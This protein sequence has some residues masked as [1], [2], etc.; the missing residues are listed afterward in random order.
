MSDIKLGISLYC[1]TNE[2][3]KLEFS[4][5]DCV[6]TAAELGATGYEIVAAQMI[7][8][9]PNVS[10]EFLAQVK[11]WKDK[12][13][14]APVSYGA[15]MDCGMV[16]GR[17]LTLE[18]MV[19]RAIIDIKSASKL[20]CKIVRQQYLLSAEGLRRIEPYAR[21]Y[22]IKVGIEMHNPETPKSKA[23][24]EYLKVIK[25]VGSEYIGLIPDF[26]CFATKPN[27]PHWEEALKNGADEKHLELAAQM[28][29]DGL[30]FNQASEKLKEVG[31]APAVFVALQ[32]MYGFVTFYNEPDVEGLKEIM[33]Y[34]IHFHGK[35]HYLDENNVEASIPYDKVLEV[36]KDSDFSG[37]IVSE[38]E[39]QASG[40][41]VLMTKRHLE[42]EKAILGIK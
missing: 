14:I 6:R 8:S 34:C 33:P 5:E 16:K 17:D 42:M 40:D 23:M 7:P 19:R 30:D 32:G 35:F 39:N 11:E 24:L 9:Y 21:M 3:A 41:A 25:E 22:G 37:Y 2:Y 1:F 4:L 13:G 12:Y 27:K 15:N 10:D 26:G 29:Y 18:E 38:Y 36:I 31:A 28:R 20:G